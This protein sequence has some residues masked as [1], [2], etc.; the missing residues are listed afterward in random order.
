M[1]A[2][3]ITDAFLRDLTWRQA[4]RHAEQERIN[5]WKE[6]NKKLEEEG[7]EPLPPP[8]PLKPPTQV[9]FLDTLQH[10]LAL[11]LVVSYGGTK[12]FRVLTYREGQPHSIK[13]GTYPNMTL[14][15]ARDAAWDYYKNPQKFTEQKLVGTFAEIS[16]EWYKRHV[17]RKGLRTAAEIRRHL[18][19]YVLPKWRNRKFL[20]LRRIDVNNLLD[21]IA[22]E[23][24]GPQADA[25][26]ATIRAI[27]NWYEYRDEDY[28]NPI[29]RGMR[30]S[31]PVARERTLNA[32]EVK[33]IWD[34]AGQCGIFGAAV[35]LLLLTGQRKDIVA[36]MRWTDIGPDGTWT[37]PTSPRKKS[38]IGKV[39][40]PPMALDIIQ[41]Q[42][43]IIGNSFVFAGR[44]RVAYNSYGQGKDDLD[45]LVPDVEPWRLHDLRRTARSLMSQIDN[46]PTDLAERVLGHK[47]PGVRGVYDRYD[48]TEEKSKALQLLA[49]KVRSIVDPPPS[50]VLPFLGGAA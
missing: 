33:L 5:K 24:G 50:N 38:D 44:G 1:P 22:D 25:V 39:K 19:R 43:K 6:R 17:E 16:A 28:R 49:D 26:L 3:K 37:I 12:S 45:A 34:A 9:V 23:H 21:E 30:R 29:I 4:L 20:E 47:I 10:G 27:M 13:L 41:A 14:K 36:N 18:D 42:P 35:K 2:K 32:T 7:K 48:R 40:L 11:V 15:Q 8:Q 46:I 31:E